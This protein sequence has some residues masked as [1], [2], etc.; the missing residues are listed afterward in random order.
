[1]TRKEDICPTFSFCFPLTVVRAFCRE[2]GASGEEIKLSHLQLCF[3]RKWQVLLC[4]VESKIVSVCV[5]SEDALTAPVGSSSST[6]AS[7]LP[8][9]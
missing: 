3:K 4:F 9:N 1:M 7:L 5:S 8:A 2:V 6:N